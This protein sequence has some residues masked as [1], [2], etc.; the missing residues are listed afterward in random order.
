MEPKNKDKDKD[1]EPYSGWWLL[2]IAALGAILCAL[3]FFGFEWTSARNGIDKLGQMGDFFGG[4]LNPLV[5]ALTLFVAISVWQ[6]QKKELKATQKALDEQAKTAEQQRQEQRFFDLLNVYQRTVD[7]ISHARTQTHRDNI[8]TVVS[9][10]KFALSEYLSDSNDRGYSGHKWSQYARRGHAKWGRLSDTTMK[11][12]SDCVSY[13][14]R[15]AAQF[16]HYFRVI[17]HILTEA[18]ALLG[19]Q[20]IRYIKLFRAQLSRSELIILGFNLWLD[21]E[22]KKM[23]PLA[24]KYSLLEHLPNG[25]LR[26]ELENLHPKVFGHQPEATL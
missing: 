19:D 16:D 5:S 10:G 20:H 25:Q 9:Q 11:T 13:W 1:A 7:S 4:M 18:E 24:E 3:L 17:F 2:G 14:E 6:L 23:L 8:E 22:G 26:T 12:Y 21:D 15:D